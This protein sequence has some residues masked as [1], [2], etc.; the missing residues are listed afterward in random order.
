MGAK[1]EEDLCQQ[2]AQNNPDNLIESQGKTTIGQLAALI[3]RCHMVV[4]NDGGPLHIAVAVKTKTVS[5]FG[6]VDEHVYGPFGSKNDHL[7]V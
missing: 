2:L 7:V 4:L 1:A 3:Q 6:P 5:I